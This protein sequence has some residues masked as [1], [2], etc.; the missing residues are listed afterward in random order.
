MADHTHTHTIV[1]I[2]HL[3][4]SVMVC[5]IS[6]YSIMLDLGHCMRCV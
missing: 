1:A 3:C 4:G 5:D 2:L 6:L